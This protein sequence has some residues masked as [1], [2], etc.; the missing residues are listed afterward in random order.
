MGIFRK[1]SKPTED[2]VDYK[3]FVIDWLRELTE[4]DYEKVIKIVEV[5]READEKVKV[6]ELGSKKALKESKKEEQVDADL[7]NDLADLMEA[8]DGK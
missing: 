6:I 2:S 5:Y 1:K 8:G 3:Q 7:D 4:K